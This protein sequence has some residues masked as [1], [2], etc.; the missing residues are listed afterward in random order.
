MWAYKEIDLARAATLSESGPIG[1]S[2]RATSSLACP[3][4]RIGCGGRRI[5]LYACVRCGGECPARG[6]IRLHDFASFRLTTIRN[7][8]RIDP[9]ASSLG[10]S[11]ARRRSITRRFRSGVRYIPVASRASRSSAKRRLARPARCKARSTPSVPVMGTP[12]LRARRRPR[13]SSKTTVAPVASASAMASRSP[14]S[15]A[16]GPD[17]TRR[18]SPA[19]GLRRS[20]HP[21]SGTPPP[22]PPGRL[23][24]SSATASGITTR[25]SSLKASR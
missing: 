20:I 24:S 4:F 2:L 3:R 7:P 13:R 25:C 14:G 11:P 16:G 22:G 21:R 6:L 15:T 1:D 8:Q 5:R 18:T 19:V 17:A 12:R 23:L 10:A 9:H